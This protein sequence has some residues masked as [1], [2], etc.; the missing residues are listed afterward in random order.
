[1]M[2]TVTPMSCGRVIPE[3]EYTGLDA[4][5]MFRDEYFPTSR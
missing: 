2:L 3:V 5:E 4:L 1:M